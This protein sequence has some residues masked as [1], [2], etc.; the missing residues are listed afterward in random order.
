MDEKADDLTQQR[1][2]YAVTDGV[3]DV[4]F[5]RADKM[6]ALDDAMFDAIIE[7][8]KKLKDDS[9]VRVVVLSGEGRAFCAG[10]D[11]GRFGDMAA[12]TAKPRDLS[13][14]ERIGPAK[15]KGQQAPYVWI[16]LPV[17]VIA[18][19]HGF[20]FGGGLQIA[21]AADI[22][23]AT[24]DAKLSVMEMKWGLIP[25]MTGSQLLP[26]LVGRD[27]AKE[28][29]YTGRIIGGEE[30]NEIGLVTRL[31]DD[32]RKAALELAAE[33]ANKSPQAIRYAKQLLEMA[34]RVSIEEGFAAE[35]TAIRDLIGS[36]NQVEAVAANLEKRAPKF[37]DFS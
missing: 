12:G 10:L 25:D 24:P 1:V 14:P 34:G 5:V 36:P 2:T 20:A 37:A 35:Q 18:A 17:P 6:N 22:R 21:L 8:G 9:S 27:V 3:A 30:A 16:D 33:I 28:L 31:S 13:A 11:F 4:R 23:I 19:V 26:E 7:T 32:P 15:A 29:T